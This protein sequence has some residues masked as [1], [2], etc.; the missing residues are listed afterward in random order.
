[1]DSQSALIG[2]LTH[3]WPSATLNRAAVLNQVLCAKL[4]TRNKLQTNDV[5]FQVFQEQWF[6]W[7][8]GSSVGVGLFYIHEFGLL[9]LSDTSTMFQVFFN[10][11]SAIW[12]AANIFPGS[13][14]CRQ[15]SIFPTRREEKPC[16]TPNN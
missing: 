14:L 9:I 10:S 1:M 11:A 5:S 2:H 13:T 16:P 6:L 4:T 8:R 7:E 3:A 12:G 15:M